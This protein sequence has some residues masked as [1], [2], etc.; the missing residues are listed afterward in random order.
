MRGYFGIGVEGLSKPVNAAN[1]FRSAHA[2][3]ASFVFTLEAT[4]GA[5]DAAL[6]TSRA[7]ENMP[8][9]HWSGLGEMVF[10]K[11]CVLVGVELTEDAVELPSFKHPPAAAYV[12]GRERGSLSAP[13]M[14]RCSHIVKIPARFCVNLAVAGA[15]VMYDRMLTHGR[16]PPRPLMP[17]GPTDS[18]V[19]HRWGKP[20]SRKSD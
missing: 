12:L 1:L 9:Y 16:F 13:L 4:Y 3:G 11:G 20:V 2:F 10:P 7:I 8:Y 15:I 5:Q 17:G 18:A 14:A 6:D 19:S